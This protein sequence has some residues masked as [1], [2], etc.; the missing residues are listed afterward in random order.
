MSAS[1]ELEALKAERERLVEEREAR[2][3]A[4]AEARELEALKI[5][6]ADEQAIL[7]AEA[8]LGQVGVDIATVRSAKGHGVVIVKRPTHA[9]YRLLV[10]SLRADKMTLSAIN[11]RFVL[12]VL[13][14]PTK[15]DFESILKKESG[16]LDRVADQAAFLGGLVVGEVQG[17]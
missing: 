3:A 16:L 8:E 5:G 11:E 12:S 1:E 7:K 9:Q 6:I 2:E 14:H 13:V 17:K 15:A 4:R 10:D